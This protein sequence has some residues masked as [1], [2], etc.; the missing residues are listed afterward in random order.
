MKQN[1]SYAILGMLLLI[2]N[3]PSA[4]A[5]CKY[6]SQ[7]KGDRVCESGVCVSPSDSEPDDA[8]FPMPPGPK[9]PVK[10]KG[11]WYCCNPA[12]GGSPTCRINQSYMEPYEGATCTCAGLWGYGY[13]CKG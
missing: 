5:G 2:T 4:D 6:D 1:I 10:S 13:V 7:C 9:P 8:S 12:T 3:A 11:S